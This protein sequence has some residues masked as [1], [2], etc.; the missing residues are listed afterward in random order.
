MCLCYKMIAHARAHV[1]DITCR[2]TILKIFL[3]EHVTCS[4]STD[5]FRHI[6]LMART[7]INYGNVLSR[8]GNARGD[9]VR[10][11]NTRKPQRSSIHGNNMKI[12]KKL[13]RSLIHRTNM[14]N[15]VIFSGVRHCVMVYHEA[16]LSEVWLLKQISISRIV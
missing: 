13:Q 5:T 16:M 15:H 8:C 14:K 6:F 3:G 11:K 9:H 2:N 12:A 7:K 10:P 1:C 4:N